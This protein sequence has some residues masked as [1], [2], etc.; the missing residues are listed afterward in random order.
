MT[1]KKKYINNIEDLKKQYALEDLKAEMI[2]N[3]LTCRDMQDLYNID[4]RFLSKICK[5]NNWGINPRWAQQRKKYNEIGLYKE[6]L[7]DLYIKQE[8]SMREIGETFNIEHSV[9]KKAL[10][11]YHICGEDDIRPFNYDKY[12]ETRRVSE[13][14]EHIREYRFNMEQK[15]G[16]KLKPEEHVHHI[17]R[18]RNNNDINNLFLFENCQQHLLYHGYIKT[19]DYINPQ[20]FV[21]NIYP[22]YLET[23]LNYDWL[24]NE[25][26]TNHESMQSISI[27]CGVSRETIKTNLTQYNIINLRS[28][29]TNQFD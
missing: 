8:K 14:T 25:Y 29:S 23:F 22:T 15:I 9:V 20:E 11:F 28:L 19:H 3:R 10:E 18:N 24:Y 7:Y 21:D 17:D 13:N 1:R 12:Y 5:E 16:R 27:K 2:E 26:I 4:Q 6:N